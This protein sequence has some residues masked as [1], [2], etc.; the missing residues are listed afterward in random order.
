MWARPVA[1]VN[2]R[3]VTPEGIA[4]SVRF[5]SHILG[6]D[7]PPRRGDAVVD[8]GGAFVLPGLINA[9]DH[10]ELN[11]YGRLK[12]RDRYENASAWIDD[13]RPKLDRDETIRANRAHP[14]ASRLFIGALKNLLAGVT[15]VAHHNPRYREIGGRFPVRVVRRYGWAHSFSLERQP[16]GAHGELGGDVRER[17]HATPPAAPFIIHLGEGVDRAASDELP[18]LEAL[19]CL[20]S[21]TVLVHGVAIDPHTWPR[22]VASG[23]S[24]VWCPASNAFLFRQTAPIREFL[25]AGNGAWRHVCLGSDSRVTGSQDLLDELRAAAMVVPV[26]PAELLRMVTSAPA[27]I[28]R[29]ANGGSIVRGAWADL[30]VIPPKKEDAA[31]A[32]LETHRRHILLITID[33]TPMLGAPAL[34]S[35]FRARRTNPRS[36]LVDGIDRIAASRL[37]AG[38]RRCVIREPGVECLQ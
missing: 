12:G 8:V 2:A 24:L 28:L 9:H 17:Y 34:A 33:G 26:K 29:L 21:N 27:S 25:D 36:I 31:E 11:H 19:G 35:V 7:V 20:R 32:L 22:V 37:A 6:V 38:I 4:T 1:L 10:L 16:V 13:L 3:V 18:R 30:L 23:A 14:L 5:A 15:T